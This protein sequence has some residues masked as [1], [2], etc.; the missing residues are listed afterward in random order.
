MLGCILPTSHWDSGRCSTGGCEEAR[1]AGE[2]LCGSRPAARVL[3]WALPW[4]M[5][6]ASIQLPVRWQ[7]WTVV[8]AASKCFWEE[9]AAR[10][11]GARNTGAGGGPRGPPL[12]RHSWWAGAPSVGSRSPILWVPGHVP[13]QT[14]CQ[15]SQ[16]G[17]NEN[18]LGLPHRPG[19]FLWVCWEG[20]CVHASDEGALFPRAQRGPRFYRIL[21]NRLR[22][23][24]D[25]LVERVLL[26]TFQNLRVSS[27]APVT[28]ASPSG[29]MARYRTR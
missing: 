2:S 13:H 4:P 20:A 23:D 12:A 11:G 7:V 5:R 10:R 9:H 24:T 29:D 22:T 6:L 3:L 1:Q 27:P 26:K 15:G 28:M 8:A 16:S 14:G 21:V 17:F 19:S 25:S 18:L